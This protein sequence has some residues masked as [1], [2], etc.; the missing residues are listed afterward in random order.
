MFLI[1]EAL[2]SRDDAALN[3]L[4]IL[5][6]ACCARRYF[7]F[8][9]FWVAKASQKDI[10][11]IRD[12]EMDTIPMGPR[13]DISIFCKRLAGI[14]AVC[15]NRARL[16]HGFGEYFTGLQLC[17]VCD[18]IYFPKISLSRLQDKFRIIGRRE[19]RLLESRIVL[20]KDES[21]ELPFSFRVGPYYRWKDIHSLLSQGLVQRLAHVNFEQESQIRNSEE[22]G[23]LDPPNENYDPADGCGDADDWWPISLTLT[24]CLKNCKLN[25]RKEE[26]LPPSTIEVASFREFRYR[27]DPTW[28]PISSFGECLTE[29]GRFAR[30]WARK[31]L[32]NERPWRFENFPRQPRSPF[33][34]PQFADM[35]ERVNQS[36]FKQH[37]FLCAKFR[38]VLKAF[39]DILRSPRTWLRCMGDKSPGPS[40]SEAIEIAT[41][42]KNVWKEPAPRQLDFEI[43]RADGEADVEFVRRGKYLKPGGSHKKIGR[44][45]DN[46]EVWRVDIVRISDESINTISQTRVGDDTHGLR[47]L[48]DG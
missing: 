38:A 46:G 13:T 22:Y 10:A 41:R 21:G 44:S 42:G 19:L 16:P 29:Y 36:S 6:L 7:D 11:L 45:P 5:N 9:C 32:W 8:I 31:S 24:D 12:L 33:I 18:P 20:K 43:R 4:A 30:H 28:R 40:I 34:Y 26:S 47:P 15:N 14:C 1:L 37:Q 2:N 48:L 23:L 27:F 17:H 3:S 39:P 35:S 25:W